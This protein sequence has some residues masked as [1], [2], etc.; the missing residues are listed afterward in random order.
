M[1]EKIL[2]IVFSLIPVLSG[3]VITKIAIYTFI[4]SS[5][6]PSDYA[7][8]FLK[9]AFIPALI[10]VWSGV[11]WGLTNVIRPI[12]GRSLLFVTL[13]ATALLPWGWMMIWFFWLFAA[14]L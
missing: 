11:F 7:N 9:I 2:S 5:P 12:Q 10:V 4:Y 6:P 1:K 13:G 8:F 14:A 3:I